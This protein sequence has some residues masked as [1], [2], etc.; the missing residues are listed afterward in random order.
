MRRGCGRRECD[1]AGGDWPGPDESV[2]VNYSPY[3]GKEGDE[4]N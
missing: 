1:A 2:R 4:L 3:I